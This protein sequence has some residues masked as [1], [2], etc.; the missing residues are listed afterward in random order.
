[1]CYQLPGSITKDGKPIN[2]GVDINQSDQAFMNKLYP[3]SDVS[4]GDEW[5]W[6]V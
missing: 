6:L 2:G 4:V 5:D 1:M 3:R